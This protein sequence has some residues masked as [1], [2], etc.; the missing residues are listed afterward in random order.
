MAL[1]TA[2][3][4]LRAGTV[5]SLEPLQRGRPWES[6]LAELGLALLSTSDSLQGDPHLEH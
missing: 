5:L 4:P 6:Q 2:A 3:A 1:L